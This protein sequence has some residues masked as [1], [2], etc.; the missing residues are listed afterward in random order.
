MSPDLI[1]AY[2]RSRNRG[3]A[4]SRVCYA[5]HVNLF[6]AMNGNVRVCCWNSTYS[7]GNAR[8]QTW[9]EMWSGDRVKAIRRAMEAYSFDLGCK[10]C[11]NQ[12][13]TGWTD[14]V[15]MRRF[16]RF[17]FTQTDPTWPRRIEFSISNSCNLECIMCSGTYSSAIRSHR[18]GLPPAKKAYSAEFIEFL[19]PFLPHLEQGEISRRR[20]VSDHGIL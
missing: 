10:F 5:P 8:N 20:A 11:E 4:G 18:E 2:D 14:N 13:A 12:T 7:L 6:L 17:A 3:Q 15:V 19:R 16:D 9:Q 1:E